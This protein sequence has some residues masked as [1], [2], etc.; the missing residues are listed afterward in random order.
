MQDF[1]IN[2]FG[3]FFI[4]CFKIMKTNRLRQ[5]LTQS[6]CAELSIAKMLLCVVFVFGMCYLPSVYFTVIYT[7]EKYY[8]DEEFMFHL[9]LLSFLTSSVNSAINFII[10]CLMSQ[11]FRAT[12]M[13]LWRYTSRGIA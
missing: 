7:H 3:L 2:D 13:G 11:K 10:Y 6:H 12:L 9:L 8:S 5:T 4:L 1:L